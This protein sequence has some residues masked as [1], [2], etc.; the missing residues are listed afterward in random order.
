M[1]AETAPTKQRGRPFKAGESGNPNG[2][3]KGARNR[4]T[5]AAETLLDGEADAL[6]RKAI[7]L[8]L[9]GDSA[10]LKLCMERIL[11]VRRDRPVA[12]P[13]P[14]IAGP[15]DAPKAMAQIIAAVAAGEL[16][17]M[18]GEVLGK[19]IADT[20]R[21]FE[22]SDLERRLRALEDANGTRPGT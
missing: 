7:E 19:L 21:S 12:C 11:P 14:S 1:T 18:E 9:G 6:T 8:A 3:P 22:S 15:Q 13:I 4:A 2:R 20:V 16:T 10:A 17:P 5:V